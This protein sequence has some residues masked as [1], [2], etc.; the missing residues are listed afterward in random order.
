MSNA[1]SSKELPSISPKGFTYNLESKNTYLL[2]SA[3]RLNLQKYLID[4]QLLPITE[5]SLRINFL[6]P[7]SEDIK[8][9][10][11][12]INA[13]KDI[14]SHCD[15]F[16]NNGYT[17]SVNLSND[18]MEFNFA[19]K[20]YL[21][22][23]VEV[24]SLFASGGI[25]EEAANTT[26]NVLIDILMKNISKYIVNCQN[27]VDGINKF[28][29]ETLKDD[30]ILND[31]TTGLN[32]VYRDKFNLNEASLKELHDKID[33]AMEDLSAETK[34]YNHYVIVAAT[35]PTY[36]WVP[37][38]GTIPAIVVAGVYGKRATDALKN[39]KVYEEELKNLQEDE[40]KKSAMISCLTQSTNQIS[41]ISSLIQAAIKPIEQMKGS[42]NAIFGDLKIV[43]NTIKEDIRQLPLLLKDIG[44]EKAIEE[45]GAL[46]LDV[47]A[48]RK[49][50][51]ISTTSAKLAKSNLIMFPEIPKK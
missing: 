2:R 38:I 24:S 40:K 41:E 5:A 10:Q 4:G 43:S 34:K 22:K 8:D 3:D 36:V 6:I 29:R 7:D 23:I 25:S 18:I 35:T 12:I 1:M 39:M 48:Y 28:Y 20:H 9:F 30:K 13:F 50:A 32:K 15:Y 27:V 26:I 33:K 37:I 31:K 17:N 21:K 19:A 14:Q 16:F 47:D 49:V 46:A 45:W 11:D 42:W 51:F 44:A